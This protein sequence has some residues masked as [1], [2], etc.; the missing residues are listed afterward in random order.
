MT[1]DPHV[2]ALAE[3]LDQLIEGA[4]TN[5]PRSLQ[6]RIGPSELGIPCDL[7]IGYKLAGHPP[8]N[9]EQAV[10]WKAWVGTNVHAG[11]E[12]LLTRANYS[13]PGWATDGQVRY[14][15]E[16]RVTV[17]QVNGIDVN[18]NCDLYLDRVV[19]DW[20]I[21][22]GNRLREYRKNGPGDQYR[23][24]AHLYGLG[25]ELKG[26]PVEHVAIYFLPRDQEWKQRYLWSEPYDRSV[27][28]AALS[29]A[30]G[31]SKLVAALGPDAFSMLKRRES[32]CG[33]CAYR[34]PG[35]KNL[36]EGCPGDPDAIAKAAAGL[37]DLI[38]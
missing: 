33:S 22:G 4:I 27:A 14:A 8:T 29:R 9:T 17:G 30:D 3:E 37:Q 21:P 15:L 7:R 12:E 32:W 36:A 10:K 35:S 25:W 13:L 11:I 6:T 34:L 23:A 24:Q 31:I 5:A 19:W 2:Q 1:I 26:Y 28:E 20:K 18:G 16:E 38:A